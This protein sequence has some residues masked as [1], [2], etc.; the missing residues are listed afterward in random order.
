M[1][2]FDP[3]PVFECRYE[4]QIPTGYHAATAAAGR[5]GKVL[6]AGGLTKEEEWKARPQELKRVINSF[7]LAFPN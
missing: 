1:L 6:L 5:A 4:Y 2:L 7:Q 3:L